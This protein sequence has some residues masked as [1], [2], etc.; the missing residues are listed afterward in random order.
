MHALQYLCLQQSL[1]TPIVRFALLLTLTAAFDM[2]WST[3]LNAEPPNVVIIISD[4]QAWSDYGFMGHDVIQTPNL[5]K[6][7]SES[8]LF[9]R[10]YVVAPLCRPSLAS[11]VTGLYPHQHGVVA[12]DVDPKNRASSDIALQQV[13]HRNNSLIRQLVDNGYVAFQSGKW[14]EGSWRDGGFT[15]GMTHGDPQRG[16]RHGDVGL[17]IG[18]TGVGPVTNFID[19]SIADGKPFVVWYA[20]FLPHTPHNPPASLLA[21]YTT[22]DR[23]LNVARYYAMCD[24]FDQTCGE[25]LQLID[26]TGVRENTVVVYVCDNGWAPVPKEPTEAST[27]SLPKDWW[28]DFAPRSKGSPYENGIRTPIMIS[29]P[30]GVKPAKS[31]DLASS[32]D[33]MPTI[34]TACGIDRPAGLPGVNLLDTAERSKRKSV[35]GGVW[36]IH[37]ANVGDPGST[38]QYRYV[39]DD[40]WKL[41]D[42]HSGEDI[43]SY[44]T[45][46]KWDTEPVQLFDLND[47][48]SESRNLAAELPETVER[49]RSQLDEVIPTK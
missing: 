17:K 39:V 3:R 42:R 5:D 24:W 26:D 38:L 1:A 46:H 25:L 19:Q 47:D 32:I 45:V 9:T 48:Q 10:G 31:N 37:N 15:D 29:W 36:S 12:N 18:R 33:L 49:L 11:M 21:K 2:L 30:R 41:I 4:D 13:F 6:L 23:P 7:A 22:D 40:R 16:G 44:K 8:L 14:W 27:S 43:T 35:F 28:P 34:L 20:P